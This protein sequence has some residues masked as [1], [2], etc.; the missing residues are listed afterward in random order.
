MYQPGNAFAQRKASDRQDKERNEAESSRSSATKHAERSQNE[1]NPAAIGTAHGGSSQESVQ[2]TF[3]MFLG[4][5]TQD[6]GVTKSDSPARSSESTLGKERSVTDPGPSTFHHRSAVPAPLSIRQNPITGLLA[7]LRGKGAKTTPQSPSP[8]EV[9]LKELT[10]TGKERANSEVKTPS[11]K[12]AP[13]RPTRPDLDR[14]RSASES[15][16]LS[17]QRADPL[18]AIRN[19][20]DT[21]FA[22]G[23]P[24]RSSLRSTPTPSSRYFPQR[25]FA[26]GMYLSSGGLKPT[27]NGKFARAKRTAIVKRVRIQSSRAKIRNMATPPFYMTPDGRIFSGPILQPVA[28][29]PPN[30]ANSADS[31]EQRVESQQVQLIDLN[32]AGNSNSSVSVQTPTVYTVSGGGAWE[33]LQLQHPNTLLPF[34]GQSAQL[35]SMSAVPHHDN[36]NSFT[37]SEAQSR[38]NGKLTHNFVFLALLI[39]RR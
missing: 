27:N 21:R 30:S 38:T 32:P 19:S 6:L 11:F 35:E 1:L 14:E 5:V 23:L 22:F 33:Q 13:P 8:P 29:Q 20:H 3:D 18:H 36:E 17:N 39:R 37:E 34:R 2:T 24:A 25:E 16:V 15:S 12:Q 9:P 28:Y 31:V 10:P 7:K 4:D 26:D